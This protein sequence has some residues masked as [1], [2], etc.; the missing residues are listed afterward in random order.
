MTTLTR[1]T[2]INNSGTLFADNSSANAGTPALLAINPEV[3]AAVLSTSNAAVYRWLL[4]GSPLPGMSRLLTEPYPGPAGGAPTSYP[5]GLLR[6]RTVRAQNLASAI[7][8]ALILPVG[9]QNAGTIVGGYDLTAVLPSG[10]FVGGVALCS[11]GAN[12]VI[13][14]APSSA[15]SGAGVINKWYLIAYDG[16]LATLVRQG[17]LDVAR[18]I[19]EFGFGNAATYHFAACMLED[20][21]NHIWVGYGAGAPGGVV[22][23]YDLSAS[24]MTQSAFFSTALLGGSFIL[25]SVWA[26]NGYCLM[27]GVDKFSVFRRSGEAVNPFPA[28]FWPGNCR[29]WPAGLVGRGGV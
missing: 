19:Y 21:L 22:F 10:E 14:T 17:T 2:A 3:R 16:A 27:L 24:V 28:D 7:G 13:F 11:N 8:S 25:P 12:A 15:T 20:D 5:V 4:D 9:T 1:I 6:G 26:E 29:A 18:S 23:H